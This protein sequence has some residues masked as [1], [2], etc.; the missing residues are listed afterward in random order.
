MLN[1]RI[2][3]YWICSDSIL[4]HLLFLQTFTMPGCSDTVSA[5]MTP[6]P[7]GRACVANRVTANTKFVSQ[8]LLRIKPQG[9]ENYGEAFRDASAL[10]DKD[11]DT[12]IIFLCDGVSRDNGAASCISA[13][14]AQM[15]E[16]LS[17]FCITLGPGVYN[18][19][20]TVKGT[21]CVSNVHA[22][23]VPLLIILFQISV[24]REMVKWS[25]H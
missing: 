2:P 8:Y 4:Y 10:V 14:R 11:Q 6:R 18:N 23:L 13:L 22:L 20:Q 19:N 16:S 21:C 12:V 15:E 17:L 9:C 1:F 25:R 5:V 24:L 7:G 3:N